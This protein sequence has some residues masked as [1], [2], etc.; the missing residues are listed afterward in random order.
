MF[1]AALNVCLILAMLM[2]P[3]AASGALLAT[4]EG[5]SQA[6]GS[7]ATEVC[8]GCRCCEVESVSQRCCCCESAVETKMGQEPEEHLAV[9][10]AAESV[11]ISPCTCGLQR[12][13]VHHRS[14]DRLPMVRL[15]NIPITFGDVVDLPHLRAC[16]ARNATASIDAAH[17]QN[18]S[19][20]LLCVWLI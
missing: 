12:L 7:A 9:L 1:P 11:E 4:R 20:T 18:F 5:A 16:D 3:V 14:G 10:Q 8:S 17:P 2:Q 13:P 15:S 6:C 19:Q